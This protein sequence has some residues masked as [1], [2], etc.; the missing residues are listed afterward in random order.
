MKND[1]GIDIPEFM[2]R[3]RRT[4]S[5]RL[6]VNAEAVINA[7]EAKNSDLRDQN[8]KMK[9]NN[10]KLLLQRTVLG[11]TAIGLL[12]VIMLLTGK[13]VYD[14]K[15]AKPE[16][17]VMPSGYT[18]LYIPATIGRSGDSIWNNAMQYWDDSLEGLIYRDRNHYVDS[19]AASNNIYNPNRVQP[20]QVI[21]IPTLVSTDSEAFAMSQRIQEI[22]AEIARIIADEEWVSYVV[23]PGDTLLGIAGRAAGSKDKW[24]DSNLQYSIKDRIMAK[25]GMGNSSFLRDG[26]TIQII[27]P[28]LGPLRT[29]LN[30]LR[31]EIIEAAKVNNINEGP[32]LK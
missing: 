12:V 24:I 16:P 1:D 29:E 9:K 19:I 22:E 11:R 13:I 10:N 8:Q 31:V 17:F 7:L 5:G 26:T 20:G 21:I 2:D 3:S 30:T 18:T 4:E 23:R 25:N 27:N 6:S 14:N 28:L 32:T 15:I